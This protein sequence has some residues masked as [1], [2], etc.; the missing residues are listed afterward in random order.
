[1][2]N[3]P[4]PKINAQTLDTISADESIRLLLL[5]A[6]RHQGLDAFLNKL[7]AT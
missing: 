2:A 7:K 6:G 1:M 3:R 4:I 5:R